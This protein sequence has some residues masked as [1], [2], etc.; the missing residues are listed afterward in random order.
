MALTIWG[1]DAGGGRYA[2]IAALTNIPATILAACFHEF[3]LADS[4]RGMY[5][6]LLHLPLR[7]ADECPAV[8]TPAHVDHMVGHK[9]HMEH[10]GLAPAP[11][12]R[13]SPSPTYST[14]KRVDIE[15]IERV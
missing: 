15:T 6:F 11:A 10:S 8:V 3:I 4:S 12:E 7:D 1:I 2:A 5:L 9:A 13:S 14:E